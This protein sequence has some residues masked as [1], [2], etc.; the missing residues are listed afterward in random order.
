MASSPT[1]LVSVVPVRPPT[2]PKLSPYTTLFRSERAS[3][4]L[5]GRCGVEVV[6]V[7]VEGERAARRDVQVLGEGDER[8]GGRHAHLRRDRKRTR[9][10]SSHATIWYG[11]P[12]LK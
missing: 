10:N 8:R 5:D 9:L 6:A 4:G 7:H 11:L 3:L 12:C 2:W 1:L